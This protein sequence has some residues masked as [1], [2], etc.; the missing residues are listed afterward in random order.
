MSAPASCSPFL[1]FWYWLSL[2]SAK[3]NH[4]ENDLVPILVTKQ[5]GF[6]NFIYT[7]QRL[8]IV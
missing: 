6:P 8:K 2:R 7:K 4:P 3:E 5:S 1:A